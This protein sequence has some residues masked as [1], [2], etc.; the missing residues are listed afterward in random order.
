MAMMMN[1]KISSSYLSTLMGFLFKIKALFRYGYGD[2]TIKISF[3]VPM[4]NVEK[5]LPQCLDSI[6]NQQIS[7]EIILIDDGS[8]DNTL[9]IAL[10]Y[11]KQHPEIQVLVQHNHGQS[12]A[13]NQG[14]HLARGEYICFIDSD[15]FLIGNLMPLFSQLLDKHTEVDMLRYHALA[16]KPNSND[17]SNGTA[18]NFINSP[19]VVKL[20]PNDPH[21]YIIC[22]F[23]KFFENMVEKTWTAWIWMYVIRRD[24]LIKH[25]I[26]FN[27][28]ITHEDNM[29]IMQL[30]SA[31]PDS[32]IIEID[33]FAYVYHQHE[34]STMGKL[35][36]NP[37]LY[38]TQ[39]AN[40]LNVMS[41]YWVSHVDFNKMPHYLNQ[42]LQ[43]EINVLLRLYFNDFND[44]E[45]EQHKA[46]LEQ[47]VRKDPNTGK[48]YPF[49]AKYPKANAKKL[50]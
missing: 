35:D 42:L 19:R 45:R 29:F 22:S 28:H 50:I 14:I 38:F 32:K 6:L 17:W 1:K 31:S 24:F 34:N 41:D 40:T 20:K 12:H 44:Q 18:F 16:K 21:Q 46:L 43:I 49:V 27:E 33:S 13:R 10:K 2:M 39:L 48:F 30:F 11:K 8:T 9:N 5:Y 3:I 15:D 36:K 4:Y 37:T 26:Y 23:A 7:K 25:H 47:F